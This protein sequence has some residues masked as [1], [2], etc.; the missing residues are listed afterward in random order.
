MMTQEGGTLSAHHHTP[1]GGEPS[2]DLAVVIVTYNSAYVLD[3]ALA[4]LQRLLGDNPVI[5]VD[6]GS[7]DDTVA[8]AESR[9]VQLVLSD[10]GNVGYGAAVNLGIRNVAS[11]SVLVI[12]PDVVIESVDR[13]ALGELLESRPLGLVSCT[14]V[15]SDSGD[16]P[17]MALWNWWHE[18]L[19]MLWTWFLKPR[20]L[21][22]RRPGPRSGRPG[23]ISGAAFLA[24]TAEW[25]TVGGFDESLFLY[26]E[27][28]DLS[29][30]YQSAS[31]RLRATDAIRVSHVRREEERGAD[32]ELVQSWVFRSLVQMTYSWRGARV[33]ARAGAA[34]LLGLRVVEALGDGSALVPVLGR[35]GG[36][37]AAGARAVLR[38]LA[39]DPPVGPSSVHYP[40][41]NA[42]YSVLQASGT[43]ILRLLQLVTVGPG[44]HGF[45]LIRGRSGSAHLH[46]AGPQGL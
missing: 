22:A 36:R 37:K 44:R 14:K 21:S 41:A 45:E 12:N 35:L 3:A 4:S 40:F 6:N 31:Y 23:W 26:Y 2:A 24:S 9:G 1:D 11:P 5:V 42:A 19:W 46:A 8:I 20:S 17:V 34:V 18:L 28:V 33:A 16:R 10:H 25:N 7:R 39:H 29:R 15:D 27:D 32:L 13:A 43:S 30:R 38:E